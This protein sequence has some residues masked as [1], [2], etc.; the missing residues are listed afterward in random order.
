[1]KIQNIVREFVISP[2]RFRLPFFFEGS[3][4]REE[5]IEWPETRCWASPLHHFCA[6]LRRLI[7]GRSLFSCM[8]VG[9]HH[10]FRSAQWS[11][12]KGEKNEE[13]ERL[14]RRTIV[15]VGWRRGQ[16]V[17]LV[18]NGRPVECAIHLQ[19]IERKS[20]LKK[21]LIDLI[22]RFTRLRQS[23]TSTVK[24]SLLLDYENARVTFIL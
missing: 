12:G 15:M 19:E 9:S 23:R 18:M 7:W 13:E 24:K 21:W 3:I 22:L 10:K 17:R 6:E 5:A 11:R 8:G 4:W 1:M 14:R 20:R 2:P 16:R